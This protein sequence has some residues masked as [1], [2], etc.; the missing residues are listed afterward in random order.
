[1][2]IGEVAERTQ[3]P[4]DTIRYYE[5]LG[6]LPRPARTS[7]NYR[8]Y[9]PDQVE[10]L[11]FIRRCRGLDMSLEEIRTL[12]VFCDQPHKHCDAVN[13]VLDE[14]I[15]HVVE[16][17]IE[18]QRLAKEL[19][20]LRNVCRSPGTAADCQILKRLRAARTRPLRAAS[21]GRKTR[22]SHG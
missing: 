11:H 6:L 3:T 15:R 4:V 19:R 9:L 12:L 1:M 17:I 7:S 10:R 14:H 21:T 5:R 16:R 8:S 2:R 13:G 18:L 20:Q 22:A